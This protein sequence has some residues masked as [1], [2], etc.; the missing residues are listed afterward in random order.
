[1]SSPNALR[2]RRSL[3]GSAG[4]QQPEPEENLIRPVS[5]PYASRARNNR[6]GT[7]TTTAMESTLGE[8]VAGFFDGAA[9]SRVEGN[10][11]RHLDTAATGV[12]DDAHRDRGTAP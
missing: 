6:T 4:A 12:D 9:D 10:V 2:M 7:P 11:A 1:M 8:R 3:A 5:P